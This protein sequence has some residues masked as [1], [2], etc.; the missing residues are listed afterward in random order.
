[1]K[2][3]EG[4]HKSAH[5]HPSPSPEAERPDF[6]SFFSVSPEELAAT[7]ERNAAARR[8]KERVPAPPVHDPSAARWLD[9][10]GLPIVVWALVTLVTFPFLLSSYGWS[11]MYVAAALGVVAGVGA[12]A[13]VLLLLLL[14]VIVLAPIALV[15]RIRRAID[16]DIERAK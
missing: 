11:A 9:I 4:A 12:A 16:R 8:E 2:R 7:R 6:V 1:M 13:L 15:Q 3:P 5:D 14:L 10:L